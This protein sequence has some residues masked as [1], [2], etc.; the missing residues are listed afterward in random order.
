MAYLLVAWVASATP[1]AVQA[2][3]VVLVRQ[4]RAVTGRSTGDYPSTSEAGAWDMEDQSAW[5]R[6]SQNGESWAL[7]TI[8]STITPPLI[9]FDF[10]C[11]AAET[12]GPERVNARG[13]GF[14]SSTFRVTG[15]VYYRFLGGVSRGPNTGDYSWISMFRDNA[16]ET[17]FTL[18]VN[19]WTQDQTMVQGTSGVLGPG[20]YRIESRAQAMVNH[21]QPL[22][23]EQPNTFS[24]AG[25]TLQLCPVPFTSVVRQ[26]SPVTRCPSE[27]AAFTFQVAGDASITRQ[28][29]R[30]NVPV[31]DGPAPGG[32][33]ISGATAETLTIQNVGVDD[34]G[35]YVCAVGSPI[36]SCT[37]AT[38]QPATLTISG[39]CCDWPAL[40][41]STFLRVNGDSNASS[42]VIQ[43]LSLCPVECGRRVQV[44]IP[45]Y[46]SCNN[47]SVRRTDAIA[48][49]S[50]TPTLLPSDQPNRVPGAIDPFGAPGFTP[51]PYV[52]APTLIGGLPTDIPHDFVVRDGDTFI[53]PCNAP[54][55]FIAPM[56][57]NCGSPGPGDNVWA[58]PDSNAN[59]Y[60]F[61]L[62]GYPT[63][64]AQPAP[65]TSGM[66]GTATFSLTAANWGPFTYQWRKD[67]VPIPVTG[68]GSNASAATATLVLDPVDGRD[69]ASYDCVVKNACL[70]YSTT[71]VP[72]ALTLC[73]ADVDDGSGTGTPGNGVDINDLLFLLSS[74]ASGG[75]TADIDDG[76]GTGTPDGAVDINDLLFFLA[77]FEVGC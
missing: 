57:S 61:Y 13:T 24:L 53:L 48:V 50:S 23:A 4:V 3:Q 47:P 27:S 14:F 36:G 43:D 49:F 62:C 69:V 55:M 71:S 9:A 21:V 20:D 22:G 33:Y 12:A 11:E 59:H 8:S 32:S 66:R 15:T 77:R 52:S 44:R 54:Y 28:W 75:F 46:Y 42:P 40:P 72:V 70:N 29:W 51:D 1:D 74:F 76:T 16:T 41:T 56:P 64:T 19:A 37:N 2:G 26:P 30:G 58:D 67:G 65:F 7:A 35:L 38:S 60:S 63:V 39:G 25:G 73:G 17:F 31:Q 34:A 45:P 10:R 5:R 18:D 6:P 68:P